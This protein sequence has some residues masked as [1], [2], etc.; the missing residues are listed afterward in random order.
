MP[1]MSF[2]RKLYLQCMAF[3]VI[4]KNIGKSTLLLDCNLQYRNS[5][6]V[7]VVYCI[8]P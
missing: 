3:Y 4:E 8:K 7:S 1:Q 5:C 2:V 6:L